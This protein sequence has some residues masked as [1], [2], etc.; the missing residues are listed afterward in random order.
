MFS[1]AAKD[2]QP[3][4]EKREFV[5]LRAGRRVQLDTTNRRFRNPSLPARRRESRRKGL[6]P[7]MVVVWR[8]SLGRPFLTFK[9]G[10]VWFIGKPYSEGDPYVRQFPRLVKQFPKFLRYEGPIP[11]RE[12]LAS[13]YP[14]VPC[15]PILP[16]PPFS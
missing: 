7:S 12:A 11:N 16:S 2:R 13:V 8:C 1:Q 9:H 6:V 14:L 3:P 5:C 4:R 15:F 10:P